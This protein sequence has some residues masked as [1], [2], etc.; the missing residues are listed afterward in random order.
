MQLHVCY[1]PSYSNLR[2]SWTA[3]PAEGEGA[4]RASVDNA[5]K[6]FV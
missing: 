3:Q 1:G 6:E 2:G 4:K 5:L